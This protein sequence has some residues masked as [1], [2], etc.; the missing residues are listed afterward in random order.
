MKYSIK[1]LREGR[2]VLEY[3]TRNKELLIKVLSKAFPKHKIPNGLCRYYMKGDNDTWIATMYT[4]EKP[5]QQLEH[6]ELSLS[7]DRFPFQLDIKDVRRIL[8]IACAKWQK[9]LLEK[10]STALI[11]GFVQ[12][13]EGFYEEMREACTMEQNKL[14]DEIFGEDYGVEWKPNHVYLLN[15]GGYQKIRVSS[16]QIRRFYKEGYLQ[17]DTI[18]YKAKEIIKIIG[19]V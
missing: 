1:D 16:E 9:K 14:F 15:V 5:I 10:W 8:N 11:T 3:T 13:D 12:V 4:P 17:G 2:V 6:F 18:E 7:D 19:P